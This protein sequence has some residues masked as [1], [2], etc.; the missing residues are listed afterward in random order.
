MNGN[1][2]TLLG[3]IYLFLQDEGTHNLGKF[4]TYSSASL[5]LDD[6]MNEFIN[7]ENYP[8]LCMQNYCFP[9]MLGQFR[10]IQYIQ[11]RIV[12]A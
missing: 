11:Q 1:V 2:M 8:D 9:L 3:N 7:S 4:S 6:F 12:V 5:W 10:Q